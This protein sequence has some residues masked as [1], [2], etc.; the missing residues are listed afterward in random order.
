MVFVTGATGLLGSFICRNLLNKGYKVRA[1][2][3]NSSKMTLLEDIADRIE[4][5]I[6]DMDDSTF[7][8]ES[9]Q[10][11][12]AII[13]GAAIISFDKR[14]EKAMYKTNVQGTADLVNAAL[15]AEVKTF[16]HISSVA[17]IGRKKGQNQLS[18][19]DK[20]EGTEYDSIYARS[21]HLSELEVWR[22]AQEG[23]E[24]KIVNPSVILGPGLW[25][26]GSTS[27]FHYAYSEKAF[28]PTGTVNYID[29]RDVSKI[30]VMLMES[31][32]HGERFILNAGT[33][34]YKEF[35]GTIAKAFGKK[36]PRKPV[37][38]NLLSIAVFFEF[39]RSR[40][41]GKEAMITAD[42]AK[43]SQM[44]FEFDNSKIKEALDYEFIPLTE[45]VAWATDK[46]KEMHSLK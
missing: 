12:E 25:G 7:L 23:L 16:V 2:K 24:V 31:E 44:E 3:R 5:V 26:K 19:K 32:I 41:T 17:A 33:C 13:H 37:P 27:V 28:H 46:L 21:K 34:Y 14:F 38:S 6:G 39:L 1:V 35:F 9:L 45:S 43:L 29:V 15:K 20:W 4:W 42:T 40:I 22:G 30:T 11:V 10:G 36:A 18:E 8:E